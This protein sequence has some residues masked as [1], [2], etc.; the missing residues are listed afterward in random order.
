MGWNGTVN[1]TENDLIREITENALKHRR[2]GRE[3]YTI[4]RSRDGDLYAGIYLIERQGGEWMYKPMSEHD[5][6]F[7]YRFPREWLAELSPPPT[8]FAARWRKKVRA[9]A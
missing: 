1:G 6:P 9:G 5:G 8:L 4:E 7:Y 2:V 3:V